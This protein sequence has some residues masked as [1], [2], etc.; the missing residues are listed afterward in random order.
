MKETSALAAAVSVRLT[1][2]AANRATMRPTERVGAALLALSFPGRSL[3]RDPSARCARLTRPNRLLKSSRC[4]LALDPVEGVA[5][6]A[7]REV[8]V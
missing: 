2:S 5:S 8:G 6:I 3:A 4:H 7:T 1:R